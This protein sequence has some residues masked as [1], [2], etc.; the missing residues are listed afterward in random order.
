MNKRNAEKFSKLA[1]DISGIGIV[2]VD[3]IGQSSQ[4]FNMLYA[5]VYELFKV[6]P[7]QF[8]PYMIL[9]ISNLS[10]TFSKDWE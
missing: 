9:T 2:A 8:L 3:N 10:L 7:K 4:G 6:I 5:F 1:A